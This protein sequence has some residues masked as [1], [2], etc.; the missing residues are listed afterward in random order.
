M[1]KTASLESCFNFLYICVMFPFH[2]LG[3]RV[4]ICQ[5]PLFLMLLP[6]CRDGFQRDD[7]V[8]LNKS[9]LVIMLQPLMQLFYV[10]QGKSKFCNERMNFP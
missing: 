3:S 9:I 6:T 2:E 7:K 4:Q 10:L 1:N 8:Y 5:S